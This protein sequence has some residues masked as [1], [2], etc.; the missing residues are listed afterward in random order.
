MS[1]S[2]F[3][4]HRPIAFL[5]IMSIFAKLNKN[6]I[7]NNKNPQFAAPEKKIMDTNVAS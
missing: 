3:P 2:V 4:K 5:S 6:Y 7:R 1:W